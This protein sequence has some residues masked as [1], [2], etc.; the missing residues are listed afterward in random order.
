M[1]GRAQRIGGATTRMLAPVRIVR[2]PAY[3]LASL[4]HG[5]PDVFAPFGT[6][7]RGLAGT[8]AMICHNTLVVAATQTP[9]AGFNEPWEDIAEIMPTTEN[10]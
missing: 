8:I 10:A 4:R 2:F 1:I 9:S 7:I 3:V 5:A 6:M